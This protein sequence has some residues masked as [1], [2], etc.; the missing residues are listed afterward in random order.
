MERRRDAKLVVEEPVVEEAVVEEQEP[1]AEAEEKGLMEEG[2]VEEAPQLPG[3]QEALQS[4]ALQ[5]ALPALLRRHSGALRVT[6]PALHLQA[7]P[8][9]A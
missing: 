3:S 5:A 6:L 4:G 9:Q 1:V 7:G 2:R 8:L